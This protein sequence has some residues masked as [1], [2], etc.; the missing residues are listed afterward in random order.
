MPPDRSL[1]DRARDSIAAIGECVEFTANQIERAVSKAPAGTKA[2]PEIFG[3]AVFVV[4]H[5]V[6]RLAFA[7]LDLSG[8]EL[9]MNALLGEMKARAPTVDLRNG[10]NAVQQRLGK[11]RKLFA[12]Q[13]EPLVGTLFWEVGKEFVMKYADTDPLA[14]P[15]IALTASQSYELLFTAFRDANILPL[16]NPRQ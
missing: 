3:D 6:D 5:L 12:Q 4:L 14:I 7:S 8:R 2:R 13:G 16:D 1:G 15:L 9:F 10:Y 11:F